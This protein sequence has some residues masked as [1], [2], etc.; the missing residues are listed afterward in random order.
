MPDS[1]WGF[2]RCPV[3]YCRDLHVDAILEADTDPDVQRK[4]E[5]FGHWSDP[6]KVVQI[7]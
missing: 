3:Q 6:L 1:R 5:R 7:Y 2:L 4:Q